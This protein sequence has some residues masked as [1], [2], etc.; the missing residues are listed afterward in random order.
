MHE[1]LDYWLL[2]QYDAIGTKQFDEQE[3]KAELSVSF[4]VS[5]AFALKRQAIL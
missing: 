1:I 4:P 5:A 3:M 2:E